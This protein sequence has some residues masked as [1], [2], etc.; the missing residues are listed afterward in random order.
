MVILLYLPSFGRRRGVQGYL[1]KASCP[2]GF[3]DR[4]GRGGAR[5][6]P[7]G[8]GTPRGGG[9][10]GARGGSKFGAKG[11]AKTIIV[12][13]QALVYQMRA[14]ALYRNPTGILESSSLVEKKTC[15]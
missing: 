2:G 4:G 5:G 14:Q 10:G 7:R 11:G 1:A 8:R 13:L 15:W 6:A 9:R 12:R 3:S